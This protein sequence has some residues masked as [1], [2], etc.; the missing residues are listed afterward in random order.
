MA[1]SLGLTAGG[2]RGN[3]Y[4]SLVAGARC[5]ARSFWP[6]GA[7]ARGGRTPR[8]AQTAKGPHGTVSAS[9]IRTDPP[10]H[11]LADCSLRPARQAAVGGRST[12]RGLPRRGEPFCRSPVASDSRTMFNLTADRSLVRLLQRQER[13]GVPPRIGRHSRCASGRSPSGSPPESPR[14]HPPDRPARRGQQKLHEARK[15][16][17]GVEEARAM[18][19]HW[20]ERFIVEVRLI[21]ESGLWSWEIWDTAREEVAVSSWARDWTAYESREAALRA[22]Q[23]QLTLG[24]PSLP[25]RNLQRAPELGR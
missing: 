4:G 12:C 11:P 23:F 21:P 5:D 14:G 15:P 17:R 2:R 25:A 7:A 16:D 19:S 8:S 22:G 10:R 18:D 20:G 1:L 13:T 6:Y 24:Y 9:S 3:H